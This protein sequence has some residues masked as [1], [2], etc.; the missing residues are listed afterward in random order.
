MRGRWWMLWAVVACAER[1]PADPADPPSPTPTT[2]TS[3]GTETAPTSSTP[4]ALGPEACD[5]GLDNDGDWNVDCADPDCGPVCDGDGD[6]VVAASR[7]GDDC[8][9][10]D[11]AVYPRALEVCNGVDDDCDGA[12]DVDDS[13]LDPA[14]SLLRFADGDGDGFGGR[15]D[16]RCI[17]EAGWVEVDGDCDDTDPAVSPAG[18]E[19]CNLGVD[20]DCDTLVDDFDP[21]LDPSSQLPFW[22]DGDGDGYGD[23]NQPFPACFDGALVADNDLDCDDASAGVAPGV[24]DTCGDGIDADCDGVDPAC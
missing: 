8:D 13:G 14:T 17:D 11:A 4:T 21:S 3:E 23:P 5:D 1:E 19:V 6:G 10:A 15:P 18:V 12:I 20:D 22:R 9:D 7:G 24:P 16:L 2:E